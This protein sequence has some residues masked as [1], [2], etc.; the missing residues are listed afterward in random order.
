MTRCGTFSYAMPESCYN[1]KI[2]KY[3]YAI[4]IYAAGV[5]IYYILTGDNSANTPF[6]FLPKWNTYKLDEN[7]ATEYLISL[8]RKMTFLSLKKRP[9][10]KQVIETI[11]EK[12]GKTME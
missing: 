7:I 12:E 11:E 10:I 5:T 3:P 4:D 9:T 2:Y 1:Q 6:G 8:V